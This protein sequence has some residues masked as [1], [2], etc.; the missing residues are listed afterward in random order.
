MELDYI[1][2]LNEHGDNVVRLYNFDKSEAIKFSELITDFL[3]D[4]GLFP[5]QLQDF[6][7]CTR[8]MS[9]AKFEAR[10]TAYK[11]LGVE[12]YEFVEALSWTY[13]EAAIEEFAEKN[14]LPE[15]L[16]TE[17]SLEV[18]RSI[19]KGRIGNLLL[20][21]D[22]LKFWN[23]KESARHQTWALSMK[24]AHHYP[25]ESTEIRIHENNALLLIHVGVS[26]LVWVSD[27]V[28]LIELK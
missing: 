13:D 19:T 18:Y 11:N 16:L 20:D 1:D 10:A 26:D 27:L 9:V 5:I 2:N 12:F 24:G 23:N 15:S 6:Q 14:V 22:N 25:D 4:I 8:E 7:T 21:E 17:A 3:H 28:C